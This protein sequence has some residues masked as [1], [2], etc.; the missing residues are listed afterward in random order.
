MRI[1]LGNFIHT[2]STCTLTIS[3][4]GFAS[5]AAGATVGS[6]IGSGKIPK[7][8]IWKQAG[9]QQ[10]P[11]VKFFTSGPAVVIFW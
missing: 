5:V 4:E 11:F 3:T 7:G 6:L 2:P 10:A 9:Q 8:S 1:P